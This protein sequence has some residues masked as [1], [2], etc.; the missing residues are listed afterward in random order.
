MAQG[1]VVIVTGGAKGI[2]R[3]AAG[4]LLDAG[5]RVVIAD[6]DEQGLRSTADDLSSRGELLAVRADV[7]VEGEVQDMVRQTVAR[8]GRVDVLINNAAL[9]SH[10][11]L[12]PDPVWGAPWPPVRDM[13]L[14]FWNNVFETNVTG[15]FLCSKYVIPHMERQGRGVIVT[16]TGG[17]AA[18]K[19]G[20]LTYA[21]SKQLCGQFARYLAEEV[22]AANIVVISMNPGGTIATEDAPPE[23][24]AAGYPG[25]EIV[26]NRFVLACDATMEM[27][28]RAVNVV[29]GRLEAAP[30]P[31]TGSG[32]RPVAPQAGT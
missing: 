10:S 13:S 15:M 9:V 16:L 23:V 2:G 12:W 7:R 19:L 29:D 27:T 20:T 5:A 25:V 14:E 31:Q 6:V 3:Y 32:R 21:L 8:F 17:G 11:H 30:L 4:T 22:R 24:R 26:G 28:G 18:E 1:K